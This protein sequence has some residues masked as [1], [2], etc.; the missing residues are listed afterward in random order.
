MPV[1]FKYSAE[2]IDLA[3]RFAHTATV[4][5][6]PAAAVETIIATLTL[7]LDVA[8]SL[9]AMIWGYCAFTA[10]TNGT[11]ANVK[12]RRTDASGTTLKA[13]GLVNVTAAALYDRAITAFDTGPTL[14]GQVYVMTLTVTAGSAASTVSAV[15]LAA[16][17]L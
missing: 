16:L 13:S 11:S 4:T 6:S 12:L 2:S 15:T 17:V 14:P 9:G 7:N 1:G 5:G 3:P 10:G 8:V